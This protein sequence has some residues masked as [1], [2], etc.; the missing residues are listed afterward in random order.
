MDDD[1]DDDDD[2]DQDVMLRTGGPKVIKCEEDD[3]FMS[4]FDKMLSDNIQQRQNEA[5]KVS[6]VVSLCVFVEWTV[7]VMTLQTRRAASVV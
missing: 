2:D 6:G 5:V 3:D 1:D 7:R 4:N